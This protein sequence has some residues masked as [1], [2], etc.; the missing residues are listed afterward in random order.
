MDAKKTDQHTRQTKKSENHS[1][2][3]HNPALLT[4][5]PNTVDATAN[6]RDFLSN[7]ISQNNVLALQ[8][9]LGNS[10]VKML[11][12]NRTASQPAASSFK[13]SNQTSKVIQLVRDAT[14]ISEYPGGLSQ[15]GPYGAYHIH[16]I[17]EVG[18]G[19]LEN[20]FLK[21]ENIQ[22]PQHYMFDGNLAATNVR[23]RNH[24]P[25]IFLWAQ[26]QIQAVLGT[27]PNLSQVQLQ[28]RRRQ[29]QEQ[30]AR[31]QA[32]LIQHFGVLEPP[33]IATNVNAKEA[34][35][36]NREVSNADTEAENLMAAAGIAKEGNKDYIMIKR[37][38]VQNKPTKDWPGYLKSAGDK[39]NTY[40]TQQEQLR[41]AAEEKR[42]KEDD[43][44]RKA[45]EEIRLREEAEAKA[46]LEEENR[47]KAEQDAK[48]KQEEAERL[49][50]EEA[51]AK[52]KALEEQAKLDQQ[53]APQPDANKA[54]VSKANMTPE[55]A[56]HIILMH[57]AK[58]IGEVKNLRDRRD[59]YRAMALRLELTRPEL[60]KEIRTYHRWEDEMNDEMR[61]LD[62]KFH[63]LTKVLNL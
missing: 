3:T 51:E 33:K 17:K 4:D 39:V 28:E 35:L 48:T 60:E 15:A 41:L 29:I 21:F 47:L 53:K 25:T 55:Q 62:T 59:Y 27:T 45:E 50:K 40:R 56:K 9:L 19:A 6:I 44:K 23:P 11:L 42:K 36:F 5:S 58:I 1:P 34:A 61:K 52:A 63:Q 37:Q 22:A 38:L 12:Q 2:D 30:S 43:D 54:P 26:A 10:Q 14:G 7:N 16:V 57:R 24:T 20:V 31:D 13:I 8:R 49:R 32:A 18:T 46:R